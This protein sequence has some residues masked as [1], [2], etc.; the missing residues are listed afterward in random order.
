MA[1]PPGTLLLG[2]YRIERVLGQGGFGAVYLAFDEILEQPCAVKE[3][4]S[5]SSD[6]GRQ[7]LRRRAP[8]FLAN[9]R[10]PNLPRV[11]HHFEIGKSQFLVMDFVEGEDLAQRMRRAGPPPTGGSPA[12]GAADRRER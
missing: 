11:T 9:L 4:R 3:N 1:L 6:G 5:F 8:Q 7:F 2:R 12:L 10:H